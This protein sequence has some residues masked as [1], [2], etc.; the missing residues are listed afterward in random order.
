[1]NASKPL[2][3]NG[4]AI[5]NDN[6][7]EAVISVKVK[8]ADGYKDHKTARFHISVG[9]P[10][11]EHPKF[12]ATMQWAMDNFDRIIICV[13]DTLQR[14]NYL[15]EGETPKEAYAHA[16]RLGDEWI[17]R[18]INIGMRQSDRFEV[19]RWSD[20]TSRDEY[21]V[22]RDRVADIHR[23]DSSVSQAVEE[24]V[25]SFWSR[26]QKREGISGD[27]DFGKFQQYSTDY[28][29]EE[30]AAFSIMFEDELAADV[31]PGSSLLPCTLFKPEEQKTSGSKYGFTRIE[32]REESVRASEPAKNRQ[33]LD[34]RFGQRSAALSVSSPVIKVVG[35]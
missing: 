19:K 31:Y 26:M 29:L 25:K 6:S 12:K 15:F 22:H 34:G 23:N 18:N 28:L 14:H 3:F 13:N 24:E 20:W 16:R 30:C 32:F 5:G 10:N 35:N 1:M 9:K 11:H 7:E 2:D 21:L 8:R 27:F 17:K 33:N 4:I